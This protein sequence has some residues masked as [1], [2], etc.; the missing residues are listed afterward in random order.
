M[1]DLRSNLF[2][3]LPTMSSRENCSVN[4]LTV[5]DFIAIHMMA[6]VARPDSNSQSSPPPP[7]VLASRAM[8][9]TDALLAKLSE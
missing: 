5:R 9:L 7:N 3:P 1:Q 8:E 6:V 2:F 4:C